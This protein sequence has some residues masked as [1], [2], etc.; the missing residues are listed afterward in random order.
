MIET[1]SEWK[2][3]GKELPVELITRMSIGLFADPA[4]EPV[5]EHTGETLARAISHASQIKLGPAG[6]EIQWDRRDLKKPT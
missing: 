4:A 6:T 5:V 1:A 3:D 2:E